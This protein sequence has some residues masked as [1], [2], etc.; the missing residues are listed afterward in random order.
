MGKKHMMGGMAVVATVAA[1]AVLVN[2]LKHKSRKAKALQM[3]AHNVKD[4]V[5][6]HAKKLGKLSRASYGKMVDTAVG[7]Y[8]SLKTFSKQELA[9][10]SKELKE[11]WE[12][13]EKVLKAKKKA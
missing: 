4:H 6:A 9:D 8:R 2:A 5:V 11:N 12:E 1:V 3:A 10:L 13:V 7:E